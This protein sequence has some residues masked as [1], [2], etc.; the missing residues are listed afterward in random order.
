MSYSGISVGWVW[1]YGP[2]GAY[3]NLI[4]HNE[5]YNI[6]VNG[7]MH[8]LAGIY[9]L[10]V[11]PGTIVR[12]NHIHHV[13]NGNNV[14]GIYTDAGSSFIRW[15][16]NIVDHADSAYLHSV[17]K[18]IVIVNNIFAHYNHGLVRSRDESPDISF[19][20]ERNIFTSDQKKIV[21]DWQGREG[22]VFRSNLYWCTEGGVVF[23]GEDFATWRALGRDAGSLVADPL[24]VDAEHGDFTLAPDSPA[25]AIGFVPFSL[26]EVGPRSPPGAVLAGPG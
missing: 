10:G 18:N 6:A 19:I 25:A 12:N 22:Y 20:V 1:G 13:G 5:V 16:N 24:F 14:I 4:E 26:A 17:G 3:C 8:D 11:S 23:N 9:M 15:E 21:L 7:W 2:S